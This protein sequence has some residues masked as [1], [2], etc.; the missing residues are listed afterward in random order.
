MVKPETSLAGTATV[1]GCSG[2][3]K[4][5]VGRDSPH[6]VFRI[7]HEIL[8]FEWERGAPADI[9]YTIDQSHN[10]KGKVEAM[11]QT[12]MMAQQLFAKAALVD[13]EQLAA[14]QNPTWPALNPPSRC[15]HYRRAAPSATGGFQRTC[16]RI[17]WTPSGRA[18]I[19]THHGRA[20]C[21]R[22]F[23]GPHGPRDPDSRAGMERDE[24]WSKRH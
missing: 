2:R 20:R 15:V 17:R 6:Q 3:R 9:A 23:R 13:H 5:V 16:L 19:R 10:L 12:V 14:V 4:F 7:F 11:I 18:G 24:A 1:F 22:L 8:Y 21:A